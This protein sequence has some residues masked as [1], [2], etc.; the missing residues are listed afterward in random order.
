MLQT[1][2]PPAQITVQYDA[3]CLSLEAR[4]EKY[5]RTRFNLYFRRM[6]L[7]TAAVSDCG[8]WGCV[9]GEIPSQERLEDLV[10]MMLDAYFAMASTGDPCFKDRV[11]AA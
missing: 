5:D 4:P 2:T 7:G 9:S 10:I 8:V 11:L 3:R 1:L 6:W